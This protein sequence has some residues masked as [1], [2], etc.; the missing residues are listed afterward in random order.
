MIPQHW[1]DRMQSKKAIRARVRINSAIIKSLHPAEPKTANLSHQ[2][3]P[4][5]H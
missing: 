3:A 2:E 5:A 4:V 1:R